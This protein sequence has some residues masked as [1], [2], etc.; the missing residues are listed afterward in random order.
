MIISNQEAKAQGLLRYFTGKPCA[1]GHVSE[2]LVS[3]W[4][5]VSCNLYHVKKRY[6]DDPRVVISR[7]TSY[8]KNNP[9]K[10][11]LANKNWKKSNPEQ[12]YAS[13]AKRR[14]AK[15]NRTPPWLNFGHWFETECIYKYCS[16]LRSVGLDYE[17][18]HI[19]P[20]QGKTVSGLHAPWN[21][22]VITGAENAFKGNRF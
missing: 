15:L 1:R 22:Q 21:L 17:V 8:N 14:A 11:K 4:M 3:N 9:N 5:C 10:K 12:V 2:R 19:T 13:T 18:D 16:A 7:A 6:R 20:L